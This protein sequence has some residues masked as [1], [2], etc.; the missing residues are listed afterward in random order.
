[1]IQKLS[2]VLHLV[3]NQTQCCL[4]ICSFST[5]ALN[6]QSNSFINYFGLLLKILDHSCFI[7]RHQ[8]V[9]NVFASFIYYSCRLAEQ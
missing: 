8:Y 3:K 9:W 7:L 4:N 1:M 5:F 2:L 6:L